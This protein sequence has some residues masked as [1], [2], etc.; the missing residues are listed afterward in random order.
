MKMKKLLFITSLMF[1]ITFCG[2][3]ISGWGVVR[4]LIFGSA[5]GLGIFL[6]FQRNKIEEI[7]K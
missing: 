1:L 2:A 7:L 5:W 4:S 6:E 3:L